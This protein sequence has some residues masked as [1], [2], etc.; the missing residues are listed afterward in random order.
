[1]SMFVEVFC[2]FIFCF[3][4]YI[5]EYKSIKYEITKAKIN[6]ILNLLRLM[7]FIYKMCTNDINN[8]HFSSISKLKRP[9]F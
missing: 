7:N 2:A 5:H 9:T 8:R 6:K 1:M 4:K 3:L